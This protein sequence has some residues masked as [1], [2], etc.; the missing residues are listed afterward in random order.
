M[1]TSWMIPTYNDPLGAVRQVI[2]TL[3]DGANLDCMLLPLNGKSETPGPEIIAD[4]ELI[5]AFN[6]F[7]P[8]MPF[9]EINNPITSIVTFNKLILAHIKE[10]TLPQCCDLANCAPLEPWKLTEGSQPRN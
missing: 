4:P 7:T 1:K 2:R 3:W 10:N 9:N 5:Q 8:L 6:P